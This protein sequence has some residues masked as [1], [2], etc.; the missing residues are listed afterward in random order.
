[1]WDLKLICQQ[2]GRYVMTF[3]RN[4]LPPSSQLNLLACCRQH[5]PMTYCHISI[6]SQKTVDFDLVWVDAWNY[7]T[8]Y[9]LPCNKSVTVDPSMISPPQL[10]KALQTYLSN[11]KYKWHW[12]YCLLF[13]TEAC[14]PVLIVLKPWWIGSSQFPWHIINVIL[15]VWV[16]DWVSHKRGFIKHTWA[17]HSRVSLLIWFSLCNGCVC[18][19]V[20]TLSLVI[21]KVCCIP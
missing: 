20:K 14:I 16:G 6:T 18:L 11:S 13:R 19:T 9:F 12:I 5:V 4:V 1:M 2:S 10:K 15:L 3:Q 8:C 17:S 7:K 21:S